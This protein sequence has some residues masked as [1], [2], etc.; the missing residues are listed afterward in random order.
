MNGA[1]DNAGSGMFMT[2]APDMVRAVKMRVNGLKET[3]TKDGQ[4]I[5]HPVE[6]TDHVDFMVA[7]GDFTGLDAQKVF[8]DSIKNLDVVSKSRQRL[9]E[10]ADVQ[11][12]RPLDEL[13]LDPQAG[14][15]KKLGRLKV[16]MEVDVAPGYFTEI[17]NKPR[18]MGKPAKVVKTTYPVEQTVQSIPPGGVAPIQTVKK[19]YFVDVE[20]PDEPGVIH[21]I[22]RKHI[23]EKVQ[24]RE[25]VPFESARLTRFLSDMFF[26]QNIPVKEW[27]QNNSRMALGATLGVAEQLPYGRLAQIGKSRGQIV[28]DAMR[29]NPEDA[30]RI[31]SREIGHI[32]A[33]ADGE[34]LRKLGIAEFDGFKGWLKEQVTNNDP[35]VKTR[36]QQ[37]KAQDPKLDFEDFVLTEKYGKEL[38]TFWN[39]WALFKSAPPNAREM[40]A[41]ALSLFMNDQMGGAGIPSFRQSQIRASLQNWVDSQPNLKLAMEGLRL[42]DF[43][44]PGSINEYVTNMT[45]KADTGLVEAAKA[46]R[47][48]G[49]TFV[50]E[51]VDNLQNNFYSYLDNIRHDPAAVDRLDKHYMIPGRA[52]HFVDVGFGDTVRTMDK[53]QVNLEDYNNYLLFKRIESGD[54]T[55]TVDRLLKDAPYENQKK[56]REVFEYESQRVREEILDNYT[57]LSDAEVEKM[58]QDYM[59]TFASVDTVK[60][61]VDML[62]PGGIDKAAAAEGIAELVARYGPEK[63]AIMEKRRQAEHQVFKDMVIPVLRESKMFSEAQLLRM[64]NNPDYATF[65]IAHHAFKSRKNGGKN[66]GSLEFIHEQQGTLGFVASPHPQ[67]TELRMRMMLAAEQAGMTRD[68]VEIGADFEAQ[69]FPDDPRIYKIVGDAEPK[70]GYELFATKKYNPETGRVEPVKYA[71]KKGTL[72]PFNRLAET[73]KFWTGLSA[74]HGAMKGWMTIFNPK[75]WLTNW[76][77]DTV[78]TAF[79]AP[80]LKA[81]YQVP[82]ESAKALREDLNLRRKG[83]KNPEYEKMLKDYLLSGDVKSYNRA[84]ATMSAQDRVMMMAD[85]NPKFYKKTWGEI[86]G[87]FNK[88]EYLYAKSTEPVRRFSAEVGGS[89]EFSS[90]AAM[91]RYLDKNYPKMDA[92]EK[93]WYIRNAAGTPILGRSGNWN[94]YLSNLLMF[95]NP[96][97]QGYVGDIEAFRRD[98]AGLPKQIFGQIL[99]EAIT[100]IPYMM[101]I[102]A[103]RAG[104]FPVASEDAKRW[105]EGVP[106]RMFSQGFVL[107]TGFTADGDSGVMLIPT[108]PITRLMLTAAYQT[109]NKLMTGTF[110][111]VDIGGSILGE[112]GSGLPSVTPFLQTPASVSEY[113]DKKNPTDFM[114]REA[115]DPQVFASDERAWMRLSMLTHI[116]Q[117]GWG[118]PL[119]AL[120]FTGFAR[121][122]LSTRNPKKEKPE[123]SQ[124]TPEQINSAIKSLTSF[125]V[126]N[127]LGGLFKF[128]SAGNKELVDMRAEAS[129]RRYESDKL[130]VKRVINALINK[131]PLTPEEQQL[132]RNPLYQRYATTLLMNE[133]EM[134]A[135][136]ESEAADAMPLFRM[137]QQRPNIFEE[138]ET[139]KMI[140]ERLKK[141]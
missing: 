41:E 36:Y 96:N 46:Q 58:V 34:T 114:G 21:T 78:R 63:V 48:E 27:S 115:I 138:I 79:N 76:L 72:D 54:R 97:M 14:P 99:K 84:D 52:A 19:N 132:I 45:R 12:S 129:M 30:P 118:G 71:A 139:L 112:V 124:T 122:K 33:E 43:K 18:N 67:M 85:I 59:N 3:T 38:E 107:P 4:V 80:G 22:P 28:W 70:S 88:L 141:K 136:S 2:T 26:P 133:L 35:A 94:P 16:D 75:F 42:Y 24:D 6:Y 87:F 126:T 40:A 51:M 130:A 120:G 111:P 90:K 31:L 74:I 1:F 105:A 93:N 47:G 32:L 25:T 117:Q 53:I 100:V 66:R 15:S 113:M 89:V 68:L 10:I 116:A 11:A 83:V 140:G 23:V 7:D 102:G 61:Y 8:T 128:T 123:E 5:V 29:N 135:I 127:I 119:N 20:F 17:D 108:R 56:Y 125:P 39:E 13:D 62:N 69:H 106:S 103:A 82:I 110:S 91:K 60:E 109:M 121:A 44:A 104:K 131:D 134:Q 92:K 65:V 98:P 37:A 101:L 137:L 55:K 64:E 9:E 57:N 73:G 77:R 81:L 95:Y 50:Q 86:E 49:K